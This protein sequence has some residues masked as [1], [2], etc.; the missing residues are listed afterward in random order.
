M[1]KFLNMP[2]LWLVATLGV[3]FA[4]R[5]LQSRY[6]HFLLNPVLLSVVSLIGLLL[7][8]GTGYSVYKKDTDIISFF[9]APSVVA[10]ALPLYREIEEIRKNNLAILAA[11]FCG[12]AAGIV[13]AGGIALALGAPQDVVLS[14]LPKSVTTPVAMGIA[15]KTGGVPSMAAAFVVITG[16]VGAAGGMRFMHLLGIREHQ[17]VGLAVGTAAHGLGTASVGEHGHV[18]AAYGGLALCVTAIMTSLMAP[19]AAWV[20]RLL[21]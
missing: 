11:V 19:L 13:L 3:F 5:R 8:T 20:V 21:Y 7:V 16:I 17:V 1:I 18:Y 10:L 9:L 6:R 14:L 2:Y 15:E 12:S 4:A